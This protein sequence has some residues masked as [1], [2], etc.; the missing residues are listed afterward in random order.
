MVR[1]GRAAA[2]LAA[3]L[4]AAGLA[5][6]CGYRIAGLGGE[7]PGGV[8]RVEVPIF[9]NHTVRPDL[10]RILTEEFIGDLIAAGKVEIAHGEAADAVVRGTAVSYKRDP[11]T[12]DEAGKALENRITLVM[13]VSLERRSDKRTL[14]AE[15]NVT[16]RYDYPSRGNLQEDDRLEEEAV[17]KAA[18]QMSQKLV[19]LMLEGF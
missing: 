6:G 3:A 10:S 15:R 16:I 12:F 18:E 9:Q 7:L 13:D 11:I 17:R 1:P 8:R 5:P 2:A 4:L 14:F 19:S